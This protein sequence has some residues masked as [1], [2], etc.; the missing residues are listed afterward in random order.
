MTPLTVT[1]EIGNTPSDPNTGATH[2]DATRGVTLT[3]KRGTSPGTQLVNALGATAKGGTGSAFLEGLR[4]PLWHVSGAPE[5]CQGPLEGQRAGGVA[6]GG[7]ALRCGT[8]GPA[9]AWWEWPW[10]EGRLLVGG[11]LK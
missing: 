9:R 3:S 7:G 11:G 4:D 10:G 6:G 1:P 2:N 8:P 5:V